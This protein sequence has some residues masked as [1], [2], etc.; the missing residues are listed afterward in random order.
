MWHTKVL[1]TVIGLVLASPLLGQ[2]DVN[3]SIEVG[4]AFN[5]N[6]D[7][8]L[9]S[10]GGS[11]VF[12]KRFEIGG[13]LLYG[14]GHP[15]SRPDTPLYN[16]I[17]D[18]GNYIFEG[19]SFRPGSN[20][21]RGLVT[22]KTMSDRHLHVYLHTNYCVV[23]RPVGK[24]FYFAVSL[25]P[26][27]AYIDEIFVVEEFPGSF[28]S[29]ILSEPVR[30]RLLTTQYLRYLDVGGNAKLSFQYKLNKAQAVGVSFQ[31]YLY[32]DAGLAWYAG[33]NYAF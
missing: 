29:A 17:D 24:E 15:I 2:N 23:A 20:P 31:S 21:D 8:Q 30:M 33:V 32:P 4:R 7:V 18:K 22:L 6:G 19:E 1:F 28:T 11:H 10:L 26:A 13:K 25:G 27:F 12:N 9:W 16:I 5:G 3:T 14:S